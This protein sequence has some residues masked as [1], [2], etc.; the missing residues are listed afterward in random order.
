M[1]VLQVADFKLI[2]A[3]YCEMS[4]FK[5]LNSTLVEYRNPNVHSLYAFPL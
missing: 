5:G 3:I 2:P 1:P 4:R